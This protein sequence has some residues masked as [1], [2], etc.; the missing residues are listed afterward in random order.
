[1]AFRPSA[2]RVDP[3]PPIPDDPIPDDPIPDDPVTD[4]LLTITAIT[5]DTNLQPETM[6]AEA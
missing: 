1:M 3:L 2:A 6:L 4:D 5:A